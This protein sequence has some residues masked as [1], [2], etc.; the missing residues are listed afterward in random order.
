MSIPKKLIFIFLSALLAIFVLKNY[1]WFSFFD[2]NQEAASTIKTNETLVPIIGKTDAQMKTT[3]T[4]EVELKA[5]LEPQ[6]TTVAGD[7]ETQVSIPVQGY[8]TTDAAYYFVPKEK[9]RAGN[10][11]GPPP[12]FDAIAESEVGIRPV[13]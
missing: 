11:G 5:V 4:P 12:P 3:E 2:S 1:P 7:L 6:N 13:E 8:P 9:R 10:L